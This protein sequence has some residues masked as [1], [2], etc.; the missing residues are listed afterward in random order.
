MK[1][2]S[3]KLL[4]VFVSGFLINYSWV[5]TLPVLAEEKTSSTEEISTGTSLDTNDNLENSSQTNTSITDQ[6]E[7]TNTY[8]SSDAN[9]NK[10]SQKSSTK[11]NDVDTQMGE[12]NLSPKKYVEPTIVYGQQWTA[13]DGNNWLKNWNYNT[14][15]GFICLNYYTGSDTSIT[16]PGRLSTSNG[17][18]HIVIRNM[19]QESPDYFLRNNK[20]KEITS[21]AFAPATYGSTTSQ[22][23]LLD[24]S[25]NPSLHSAFQDATNL[26]QANLEGLNLESGSDQTVI[27]DMSNIFQNCSNLQNMYLP[28]SSHVTNMSHAFDGCTKLGLMPVNARNFSTSN[29]NNMEYLFNGCSSLNGTNALNFDFDASNVTNMSHMFAGCTDIDDNFMNRINLRNTNQVQTMD[30][31]FDGCTKLSSP[32][33]TFPTNNVNDM[34]YMFKNCS[35]LTSMNLS[36]FDTAKVTNMHGMFYGCPTL[37]F[38]NLSNATVTDDTDT[39]LMFTQHSNESYTPL[40]VIVDGS[41]AQTLLNYD[42]TSNFRKSVSLPS[43]NA[44]GG[45]FSNGN[46]N[47]YYIS[48][49]AIDKNDSILNVSNFKQWVTANTPTKQGTG[50]LNWNISGT[51]PDQ[52]NSVLDLLNT[53]YTAQWMDD[54]N[55]SSDNKKIP[56]SAAL[57]MIYIPSSFNTGEVSLQ[58]YGEQSIPL[59]KT[60]TFNVGIRDQEKSNTQWKLNARLNW[61]SEGSINNSYLQTTGTSNVKQNVNNGVSAYNPSTDLQ[62]CSDVIGTSNAKITNV[63]CTLMS[64]VPNKQLNGVYDYNL[65]DISLVLPN[66][67]NIETGNYSATVTWNLVTA[68]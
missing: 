26:L 50:F 39:Y 22:V 40:L 59:T 63:D 49:C 27:T 21:I 56:S 6:E 7:K 20:Y 5:S 44:N 23:G 13:E 58:N 53:E 19:N 24:S 60:G 45:T 64:N 38:I 25:S 10:K 28:T 37:S 35:N 17:N 55:T 46:S 3:K 29:V 11:E 43:L 14:H 9:I 41:K 52:A 32:T 12:R 34:S 2:I 15:G 62:E 68:P 47:L 8:S 36:E 31:M 57:S 42:Y 61:N 33:F 66:A 48:K 54:P 67:E 1:N 16:I 65:G 18:Y 30:F 4:L 51:N